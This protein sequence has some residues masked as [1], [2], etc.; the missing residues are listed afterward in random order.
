MEYKLLPE[1]CHIQYGYPFDSE[2]FSKSEGIPLIRIRDVVRGFTETFT[3]E[4]CSKEYVVKKGDILVGMDGMFNIAKWEGQTGYLNQRVCKLVPNNLIFGDYLFYYM[5][6]ALK[7]IEDKTAFVTVKHLKAKQLNSILVPCPPIEE[8][9]KI[10]KV[11]SVI[12]QLI[13]QKEAQLEYL[14]ELIKSRFVE[15]FA[16]ESCL[17]EP[18]MEN[19]NEMFIGPFGSSLKNDCFVDSSAG[20]CVV[21]E[22]KHAIEKN[23]KLPFRYV[24][25]EK[26]D[27][28]KRWEVLPGDIIVSC[29]GTIGESFE[30][31]AAAPRGI[32]HPSIMKIRLKSKYN[33]KFFLE[34][35]NLYM[36]KNKRFAQGSGVK[37]GITA[38]ALGKEQFIVPPLKE[39]EKYANLLYHIDKSKLSTENSRKMIQNVIKYREK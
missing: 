1:V 39:Q 32:M 28:L 6:C 4:L 29:R 12:F 17:K 22:Q 30:I 27:E 21:Y 2:K 37:M 7:K 35:L 3:K 9:K 25:K 11:L 38:S 10:S 5:P 13:K 34:L 33:H 14:D 16:N 18:L 24:T 36:Q 23:I 20:Y 8:Q 31:P 19:V 26:Y 15:M